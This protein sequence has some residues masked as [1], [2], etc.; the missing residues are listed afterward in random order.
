MDTDRRIGAF[1]PCSSVSIRGCNSVAAAPRWVHPWFLSGFRPKSFSRLAPFR[2]LVADGHGDK[3][4]PHRL[5]Q[6]RISEGQRRKTAQ[7]AQKR[8]RENSA[9][10]RDTTRVQPDPRKRKTILVQHRADIEGEVSVLHERDPQAA[11]TDTRRSQ[12]HYRNDRQ[13][14]CGVNYPGG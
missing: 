11:T 5:A 14:D 6:S 13:N 8:L 3:I 10:E 9:H 1:Y 12:P 7:V 2:T 4:E